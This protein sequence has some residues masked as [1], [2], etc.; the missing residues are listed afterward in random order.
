M[1]M[2]PSISET[3]WK[4]MR[5]LWR[6]SPL[7]AGE[8][9]EALKAEDSSW[10]PK[11][12]QT[13]IGRLVKKGALG[14]TGKGRSYLY[15]PLVTEDECIDQES[16]SFLDRVFGG[17]LKPMLSHFVEH[18]KLSKKEINELKRILEEGK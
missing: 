13:L 8:I 10:H 1:D 7:S 15:H 5:I 2:P 17:S 12:A 3:E 9:L 6:K 14:F 16:R 18:R 11:T 4:I